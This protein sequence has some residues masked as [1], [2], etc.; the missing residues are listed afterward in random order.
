MGT[1]HHVL[2][3][4]RFGITWPSCDG[5]LCTTGGPPVSTCT[6]LEISKVP[7]VPVGVIP[8]RHRVRQRNPK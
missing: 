3:R 2:G 5:R 7:R 4:I 8:F 6:T 1:G